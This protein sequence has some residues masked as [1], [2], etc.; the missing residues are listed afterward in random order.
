[1]KKPNPVKVGMLQGTQ[2]ITDEA[3]QTIYKLIMDKSQELSDKIRA[4]D[5]DEMGPKRRLWAELNCILNCFD[6]HDK[7]ILIKAK[8]EHAANERAREKLIQYGRDLERYELHRFSQQVDT[9]AD[10]YDKA[11]HGE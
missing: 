5:P 1:M 6:L 2:R 8:E 9:E 7:V 4:G 10:D 11:S 3:E